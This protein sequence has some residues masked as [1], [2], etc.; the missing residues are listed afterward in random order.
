MSEKV[1][2]QPPEQFLAVFR[3]NREDAMGQDLGKPGCRSKV[4]GF[5]RHCLRERSNHWWSYRYLAS[6]FNIEQDLAEKLGAYL[7]VNKHDP[8]TDV[9]VHD[10]KLLRRFAFQRY[11]FDLATEINKRLAE[12]RES[13]WWL[14]KDRLLLRIPLALVVGYGVVLGAFRDWLIALGTNV[15]FTVGLSIPALGL[16]WFL[17]YCNVRDRIGGLPEVTGRACRVF[18]YCLCWSG[19]LLFAGWA[20]A[21]L[22]DGLRKSFDWGVAICL[23]SSSLLVAIVV[24]FFFTKSGSIADPL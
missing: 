2:R 22:D 23:G 24:Q 18:G 14:V 11:A 4:R 7:P 1:V 9:S 12:R 13:N 5:F 20:L 16:A 15:W 21:M 17:I 6:E 3:K 10:L 8:Y 19:V